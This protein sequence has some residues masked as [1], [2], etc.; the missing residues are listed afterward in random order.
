MN[1][2][3]TFALIFLERFFALVSAV[4]LLVL[5]VCNASS[6]SKKMNLVLEHGVPLFVFVLGSIGLFTLSRSSV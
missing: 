1:A 5:D 2:F 4:C 6:F 3:E